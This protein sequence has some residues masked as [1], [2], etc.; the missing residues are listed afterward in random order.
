MKFTRMQVFGVTV[1]VVVFGV[2]TPAALASPPSNVTVSTLVT[3]NFDK[4]ANLN[5]DGVEFET[6]HR[7]DVRVQKVVFAPGGATGWHH[8][9]GVVIVAVES[10]AVTFWNSRCK[11]K[12]FGPN[13]PNGAVFTEGN[14]E[15]GQVTSKDG[16]TV[17]ATFVVPNANPPVFRVEDIAPKC[18]LK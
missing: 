16:G 2:V 14:D 17:Y 10:G 5:H 18:A 1:G 12:T 11:S 4:R 15:P 8:H 6:E 7:T 3:A 13:S 9:P